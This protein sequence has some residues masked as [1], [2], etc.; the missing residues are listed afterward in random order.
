M[1]YSTVKDRSL[2][3]QAF[4]NN[5]HTFV[6]TGPLGISEK[7]LNPG[8]RLSPTIPEASV[9]S[10]LAYLRNLHYGPFLFFTLEFGISAFTTRISILVFCQENSHTTFRAIFSLSTHFAIFYFINLSFIT[11]KIFPHDIRSI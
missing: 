7:L 9:I 10:F 2:P 5:N 3:D 8:Q 1:S 11:H 6:D 4:V